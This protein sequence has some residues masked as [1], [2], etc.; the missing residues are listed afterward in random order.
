MGREHHLPIRVRS[1]FSQD[2]GTLISAQAD[3]RPLVGL[4]LL[5]P[6]RIAVLPEQGLDATQWGV[7]EQHVGLVRLDID[8]RTILCAPSG[9]TTNLV[10]KELAASGIAALAWQPGYSLLSLIGAA[11]AV[12]KMDEEAAEALRQRRISCPW[13][14]L[15]DRRATLVVPESESKAA[16]LA[17]YRTLRDYL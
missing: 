1:T 15:V 12:A 3:E 14:E 11:D 13:H 16:L 5:G 9:D 17:V 8:D 7:L 4:P 2:P 10:D 6:V